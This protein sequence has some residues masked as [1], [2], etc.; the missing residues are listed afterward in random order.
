MQPTVATFAT[1]SRWVR[2]RS[3]RCREA[4]RKGGGA[5]IVNAGGTFWFGT[6][7]GTGSRPRP[8]RGRG[9]P[10]ALLLVQN[11]TGR[12]KIEWKLQQSRDPIQNS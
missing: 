4:G 7:V 10:L 8:M 5:R 12:G 2:E 6:H 1:F 11:F 9:T 3:L